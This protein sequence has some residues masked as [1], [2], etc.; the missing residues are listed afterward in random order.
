LKELP[1]G[2]VL[3]KGFL[4]FRIKFERAVFKRINSGTFRIAARVRLEPGRMH[5]P[6]FLQ[7][8]HM[9]H[10]DITPDAPRLSRREALHITS[11]IQTSPHTVDPS[12]AE[13]L[14]EGFCINDAFL[15]RRFLVEA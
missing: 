9:L 8:F 10:I 14:V 7:T 3:T 13:R 15:P 1:G 2:F 11:F 12:E 4:V 6:L 5:P